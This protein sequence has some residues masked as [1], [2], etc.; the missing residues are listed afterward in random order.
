VLL[1]QR[2]DPDVIDGDHATTLAQI[3]HDLGIK[4]GRAQFYGQDS[5]AARK[6]IEPPIELSA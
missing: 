1:R 2:R 3:G 6:Q 5:T 4:K